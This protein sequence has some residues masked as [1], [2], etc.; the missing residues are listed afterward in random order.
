[1]SSRKFTLA[2]SVFLCVV[3]F[4]AQA[5]QIQDTQE[6]PGAHGAPHVAAVHAKIRD[7]VTDACEKSPRALPYA[8]KFADAVVSG[9][10]AS[11]KTNIYSLGCLVRRAERAV[12]RDADT[13]ACAT[14]TVAGMMAPIRELAP[15]DF[16]D[17]PEVSPDAIQ[18]M[19][20]FAKRS[21]KMS[22]GEICGEA[23]L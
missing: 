17:Q 18:E 9:D 3:S 19:V 16:A 7:A 8:L 2:I 15:A 13:I 23:G 22:D 11:F 10:V 4:G 5:R 21:A 6:A 1:M 20:A 14:D 12:P